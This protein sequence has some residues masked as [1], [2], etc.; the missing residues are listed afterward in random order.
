[1]INHLKITFYILTFLTL[2]LHLIAEESKPLL[3]WTFEYKNTND[4]T[5]K[6]I[7]PYCV[8]SGGVAMGT[9]SYRE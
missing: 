1:M 8:N 2:S 9:Y 4:S 6:V 7:N 5:I 3:K